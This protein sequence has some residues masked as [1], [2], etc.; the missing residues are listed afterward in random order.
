MC[1]RVKIPS[2]MYNTYS[3]KTWAI[4]AWIQTHHSLESGVCSVVVF[5]DIARRTCWTSV[6][7]V[8]HH[9][10]RLHGRRVQV[11]SPTGLHHLKGNL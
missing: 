5:P 11:L 1:L 10:H 3:I 7:V 4:K 6:S 9:K 8:I 2:A